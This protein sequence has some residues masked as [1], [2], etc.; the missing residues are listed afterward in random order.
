MSLF[1]QTHLF[2][3][4]VLNIYIYIQTDSD[5]KDE[6]P[7]KAN[8]PISKLRNKSTAALDDRKSII[9]VKKQGLFLLFK[10]RTFSFRKYKFHA[11]IS[12]FKIQ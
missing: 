2:P 9:L 5:S 11:L 12:K 6:T 8:A 1:S 10:R 3:H 7:A 4:L